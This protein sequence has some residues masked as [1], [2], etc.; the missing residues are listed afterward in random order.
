MI[1]EDEREDVVAGFDEIQFGDDLMDFG[2][3]EREEEEYVEMGS[4]GRRV[5]DVVREMVWGDESDEMLET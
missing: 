1:K 4:E 2:L 3:E 5:R